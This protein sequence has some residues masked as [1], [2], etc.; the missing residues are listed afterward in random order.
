MMKTPQSL[1]HPSSGLRLT[2][3]PGSSPS[4]LLPSLAISVF[5]AS[6]AVN[7]KQQTK[8]RYKALWSARV[9][10]EQRDQNFRVIREEP[11]KGLESWMAGEGLKLRILTEC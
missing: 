11:K 6:S 1:A 10:P 3:H 9:S 8:K 4:S 5:S 7:R 2:H